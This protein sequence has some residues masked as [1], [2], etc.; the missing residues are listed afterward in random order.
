MKKTLIT[1]AIAILTSVSI[2]SAQNLTYV[3]DLTIG[4]SNPEVY[5]LQQLII[6]LGFDIPAISSGAVP[7]GYF[8]QQTKVAVQRYQAENG[9]PSTGYVGP[10]TRAR[11]NGGNDSRGNSLR[12]ISPNGGE[13]LTKGNQY[14]ITWT[15]SPGILNQTG[16]IWLQSYIPP[17]AEATNG[18][19][20]MIAVR[21][22]EVI[23]KN[24]SLNSLSYIWNVGRI[25]SNA[26]CGNQAIAC[27][28]S[29]D[30]TAV[31][32]DGQYKVR[33]CPTGSNVCDSSDNYFQ[34]TSGVTTGAP[35][36]NG[37]DAPTTLTVGQ[38]GTWNVRASDPQ[39]QTLSYSV[40]WGDMSACYNRYCATNAAMPSVSSYQQS[41]TFT[42]SF[43]N[44]GTFTVRFTV[45]NNS[46]QSVQTS[47]TVVVTGSGT[48][49]G[50][51]Q[52]L[53]PRTG[54]ILYR[55]TPFV[56]RWNSPAY[57]RATYADIKLLRE[58]ICQSGYVCPPSVVAPL[59]IATNLS[60]NQNSYT[61][62][63]GT[64]TGYVGDSQV[65]QDGTY[66]IQLCET[67]SSNCVT[68][69]KF[70]IGSADSQTP[71]ITIVSPNGGETWDAN[72]TKT[73]S[74][75]FGGAYNAYAKVDIDLGRMFYPP[76]AAPMNGSVSS[77][78]PYFQ[79]TYTLDKNIAAN[80]VYNWIVATDI[81][82]VAI[83]AGNYVV[84][85]CPAGSETNCDM[86]NAE[87]TIR[88]GSSVGPLQIISPNGG[89]VWQ[90]GTTQTIRWM[91]PQ[92]FRATYADIKLISMPPIIDC[93]LYE[94][95]RLPSLTYTIATSVG[96]NQN[97]YN[98]IIG[99][100]APVVC[101]AGY[102]CLPISLPDAQYMIQICE[103]G[104]NNCDTSDSYFTIQ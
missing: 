73:I 87:F 36:I 3:N 13:T 22:P 10:L 16:D 86:S 62:N 4:S 5:S 90:K 49:P 74:W 76:C 88:S 37:I 29:I 94:C 55:N 99:T 95:G 43:A 80:A 47:S 48:T 2:A 92:Y 39:N 98:W 64:A 24:V 20:C 53:S 15:G 34:I 81:S 77:C 63:V 89:E 56:I 26:T 96:I 60:I 67:S 72:S 31:V 23:A 52:V 54:D 57:F 19:R 75:T 100:L 65:A 85:V 51:L 12:I 71:D 27:A 1:V 91:S 104:T 50:S 11:L 101:P 66:T 9:V 83:P 70:T 41:S 7:K 78:V 35:V 17:C 38:T 42:H 69:G 84:R 93:P 61:W 45:K 103:S 79:K 59:T 25:L 58:Y 32:G 30:G 28:P 44:A 46:G 68:S 82:N 21:A 18:I 33:I 8:G 97:S 14:T 6:S 102:S 40:D